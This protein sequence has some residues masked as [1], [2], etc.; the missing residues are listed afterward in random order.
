MQTQPLEGKIALVT[1]AGRGIGREIA[2]RLADDGADIIVHYGQSRA[3]AE[4]TVCLIEAKRRRA[5]CYSAD[6]SVRTDVVR[7]F[8]EIDR[9]AGRLDIVVNNAG[10]SGRGQLQ[11]ISDAEIAQVLGVNML[12]PLYITS[13]AAKRLSDNGRIVNFSSTV[14]KFTLGGAGL[15]SAAKRAVEAFTECWAKEL[16]ARGI[17]VNTVIPGATSPGMM[18]NSPDHRAFF[19]NASPFKRIGRAGEIAAVVAFLVSPEAS[20]VSGAHIMANGA[21]TT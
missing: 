10:V 4:E 11:N 6:I 16:G 7:M 13:E 19:E 20:W 15:Y 2:L 9:D 18:D 12:G 3:G 14:A 8:E 21:A 5:F 17:T 1:G